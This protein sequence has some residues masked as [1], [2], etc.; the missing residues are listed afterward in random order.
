MNC[1]F[2]PS[3]LPQDQSTMTE[4]VFPVPAA[5]K[6]TAHVD[7]QAY[8]D[9][10]RRSVDDPEGFWRAGADPGLGEAFHDS[11]EHALFAG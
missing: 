10:Y 9:L 3:L 1:R 4:H 2:R 8:R 6:S 7:P 11:E 5:L